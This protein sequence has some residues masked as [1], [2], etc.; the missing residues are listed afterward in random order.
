MEK[1]AKRERLE[2]RRKGA[3]AST[4]PEARPF[5][6]L[7]IGPKNKLRQKVRG[8]GPKPR[9]NAEQHGQDLLRQIESF[10]RTITS[11]ASNRSQDL[12]PLPEDVQ[13]IIEAK[14]LLPEQVGALGLTPIAERTDGLLVTISPDVA[15]P[16]LATKAQGYVSERTESGNPRYGGVI[17]PIEQIRPATRVD[18]AGAHL[19][20]W[21]EAGRLNPDDV[22][23]VDVELAG[24]EVRSG[25]RIARSFMIISATS[26]WNCRPMPRKSSPRPVTTSL[27]WITRCT[28]SYC[29]CEP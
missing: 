5:L 19:A 20:A 24:G 1:T 21:L 18:K 12:P 8:G 6:P 23:W 14:R 28:G 15:L 4:P 26:V 17:A 29:R 2:L 27:R 7:A 16:T 3:A 22:I 25:P 10:Q 11:Q 9:E 13:V